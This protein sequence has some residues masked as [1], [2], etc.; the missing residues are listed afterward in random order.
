MINPNRWAPSLGIR[1]E[2]NAWEVIRECER[3][4]VLTAGPGAGKTE[5]LAQRADFLL[6]TNS[7]RYPKRILAV[8]FKTDAS[9][10]LKQRIQ[11][12]CGVEHASRFDSVTFHGFA[13]RIIDRFRPV[14]VDE[15]LC[16]DYKIGPEYIAGKQ[17]TFKQLLPFALK[18]VRTSQIARNAIRKTYSHVFLDEFQDCTGDQYELIKLLFNDT[19]IVLT[20]VGDTKQTIM[21]WAGAL[22]GIFK[23]YADDFAA[24]PLR[25]FLN[26]RSQPRL[27]R[28]QNDVIRAIEAT[29]VM[30]D[31][32]IDGKGGDIL[33]GH[34]RN[35]TDE[36]EA[37][38]EIIQH[39]I[40]EERVPP[41]E[42]A[43][44]MPRQID[45]YAEALME[46]LSGRGIPF[47]NEHE[48]QDL[49]KEPAVALVVDYLT[50]LYETGQSEAWSRLMTQLAPF[51]DDDSEDSAPQIFEKLFRA[52]KKQ[53]ITDSK[54]PN[55]YVSW[56]QLVLELL[57]GLSASDLAAFSPDYQSRERLKEV[58]HDVRDRI[59]A[60][61]VE[62]PDLL[63]VLAGLSESDSV[64]L[65]TM[66]KSKGLEFHSVILLGVE[67]QAFWGKL[68]E[69]RCVFFVGISRAKQRLVMTSCD[70]RPRPKSSK[71][72]WDERRSQHGEF[73]SHVVRHQTCSLH[74]W[75]GKSA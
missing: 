49:L 61:L 34:F 60:L 13:K 19:S 29:A 64:R 71:K 36:A 12:R 28:M 69:E 24:R 54:T 6:R 58:V 50:C 62:E 10:N 66:H 9:R 30:P 53:V 14:L 20:A 15:A 55:P 39:W 63:K 37:L 40:V 65:L 59:R 45:E 52:H 3:S 8:S 2:K 74:A 26:F 47:R 42:I 25:L 67:T 70:L 51:E 33:T 46:Q 48:L 18:I 27:L 31:D 5:V 73:V 4:V 11:M 23:T 1:L 38:A 68:A 57:R 75:K 17:I 43:V 32:L 72:R 35:S 56:W 16:Q 7:C 21:G 41:C 44:L 22:D